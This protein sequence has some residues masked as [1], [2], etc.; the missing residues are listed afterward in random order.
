M[1]LPSGKSSKKRNNKKENIY[2]ENEE[3]NVGEFIKNIKEIIKN[4]ENP[5]D[6][7]NVLID[8]VEKKIVKNGT[9]DKIKIKN[10]IEKHPFFKNPNNYHIR[11]IT[12]MKYLDKKGIN[13]ATKDIDLIVDEI[14]LSIKGIRK[15]GEDRYA[16]KK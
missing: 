11:L 13:V 9:V 8:E 14:I 16:L 2:L 7:I 4:H 3:V 5:S 6:K 10:I 15:I 12:I 1:E